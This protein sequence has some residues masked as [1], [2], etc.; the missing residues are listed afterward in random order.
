MKI[1][2]STNPYNLLNPNGMNGDSGYWSQV[3]QDEIVDTLLRGRNGLFFVE[4]GGYDG[5]TDSNSLFFEIKRK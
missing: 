2:L 1:D 3:G 5:E 4:S